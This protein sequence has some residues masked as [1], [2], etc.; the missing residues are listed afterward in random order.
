MGNRYLA[1]VLVKRVREWF[2]ACTILEKVSSCINNL[3][4]GAKVKIY[5]IW[6]DILAIV[7]GT[8]CV[9]ILEFPHI[10]EVGKAAL[11]VVLFYFLWRIIIYW[12]ATIITGIRIK[13]T[14]KNE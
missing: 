1:D 2:V 12:I 8:I 4:G 9:L 11:G 7:L 6:Q 14:D 10:E 5:Q 13:R 3:H